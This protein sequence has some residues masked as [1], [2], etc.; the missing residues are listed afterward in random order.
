M[1]AN[2]MLGL[3]KVTTPMVM[4]NGVLEGNTKYYH[5]VRVYGK[6]LFE[7]TSFDEACAFAA[8]FN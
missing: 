1:K 5:T 2:V 6:I 8:K 7:S 4:V 3:K